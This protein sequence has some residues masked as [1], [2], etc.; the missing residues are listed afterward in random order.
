M[1]IT[2]SSFSI[3]SS[4]SISDTSVEISVIRSLPYF[5]EIS[6]SSCLIISLMRSSLARMALYSLIM[7][8]SC[9]NSS[10]SFSTSRLV[11]RC[12]FISRIAFACFS[13]K[14]NFSCRLVSASCLSLL[15][16]ITLITSSIYASAIHKPSTICSRSSARAKSYFVLRVTTSFWCFI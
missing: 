8:F 2:T 7:P 10:L 11:K 3:K 6:V 14:T 15:D 13:V 4:I 5:S 16:L 9:S 12:N 1:E